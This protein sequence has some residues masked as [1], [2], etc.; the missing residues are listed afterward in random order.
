MRV[1]HWGHA[2]L[3]VEKQTLDGVTRRVL[4]D[5]GNLSLDLSE[6]GPVDAVLVTHVH[7]DHLDL[8]RL[9]AVLT[10]SRTAIPTGPPAVVDTAAG[11]AL[12]TL[13]IS[14]PGSVRVADLTVQVLPGPHETIHDALP[15]VD[16]V[17]YY[18]ADDLL[19]PGDAWT[20]PTDPV[21]VLL[22]PIGAPWLKLA[23]SVDYLRA[24]GPRV[25]VPIHQAGLARAHQQLHI[26]LLTKAR[27][28][29]HRSPCA[30]AG[31]RHRGV[32]PTHDRG[33]NDASAADPFP[34]G[35][36]RRGRRRPR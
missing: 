30:R 2:C 21:D 13:E 36:A 4:L 5:P 32:I 29:R 11:H 34:A 28:G 8:A 24:V 18:F 23:E 9:Q 27:P 15:T 22:L 10:A 19:A 14:E 26:G 7:E 33:D 31:P 1:T 3:V 16:N 17:S 12:R 6:A 20:V 35:P 25:A